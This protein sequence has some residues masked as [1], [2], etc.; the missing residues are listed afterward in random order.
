MAEANNSPPAGPT[1][2]A[3]AKHF[4]EPAERRKDANAGPPREETARRL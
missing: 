4:G 3:M 2:P 1:D